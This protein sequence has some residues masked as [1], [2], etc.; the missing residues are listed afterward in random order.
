MALGKFEKCAVTEILQI[1]VF[2]SKTGHN[3]F[4]FI[5]RLEL[6]SRGRPKQSKYTSIM[7]V[8]FTAWLGAL[9]PAPS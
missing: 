1:K 4:S 8:M 3:S 5:S 7:L 9:S 6:S 2:G